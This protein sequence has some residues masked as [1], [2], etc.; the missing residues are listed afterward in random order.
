MKDWASPRKTP[1]WKL[2]EKPLLAKASE[3]FFASL[4]MTKRKNWLN[5]SFIRMRSETS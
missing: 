4:R 2:L 3:G 5:Q 1:W